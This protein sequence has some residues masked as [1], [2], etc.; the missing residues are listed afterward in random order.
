MRHR[1]LE[2]TRRAATNARAAL[3][4]YVQN[5]ARLREMVAEDYPNDDRNKQSAEALCGLAEWVRRLPDDDHR[6]AKLGGWM[7]LQALDVVSPSERGER[8]T[9]RYGF[10]RG[11]GG[12]W[13]PADPDYWLDQWS[14]ATSRTSRTRRRT[15]ADTT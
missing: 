4:D 8:E 11:Y 10:D 12:R 9:S 15:D 5:V 6:L 2:T 14:G 3:A 1:P 7:H 13:R